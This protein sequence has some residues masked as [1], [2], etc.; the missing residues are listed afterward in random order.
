M[1]RD[2]DPLV[3]ALTRLGSNRWSTR[4]KGMED[5]VRLDRKDL[6]LEYA[7]KDTVLAVIEV[8]Q[9]ALFPEPTELLLHALTVVKGPDASLMSHI[10]LP[11]SNHL[12]A[13][14]AIV[15]IYQPRAGKLPTDTIEGL[16]RAYI[17][18][19]ASSISRQ[20]RAPLNTLEQAKAAN[21][22]NPSRGVIQV[23]GQPDSVTLS[24]RSNR[25]LQAA[26]AVHRLDQALPVA[27]IDQ[28]LTSLN[29][30]MPD[31]REKRQLEAT[32]MWLQFD[33]GAIQLEDMLPKLHDTGLHILPDLAISLLKRRATDGLDYLLAEHDPIFFLAPGFA[34][35]PLLDH[36]S[37]TAQIDL[38]P[39]GRH[40]GQIAFPYLRALNS[41]IPPPPWWSWRKDHSA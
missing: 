32:L 29:S 27:V 21:V 5:L 4:Q 15:N 22:P 33:V 23:V 9:E 18:G 10:H 12:Y 14:N 35:W 1:P 38:L 26:V 31:C 39:C 19:M 34:F 24:G 13:E 17:R 40:R 37:C 6:I 7:L 3:T 30:A 28:L 16:G 20:V 8:A 2:R 11:S 36:L 25:T 41:G